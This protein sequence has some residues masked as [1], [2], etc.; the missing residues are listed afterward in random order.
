MRRFLYITF[1]GFTLIELLIVFAVLG[2]MGTLVMG[3]LARSRDEQSL[4]SSLEMTLALLGEARFKTLASEG[5]TRYGIYLGGTSIT[6]FRGSVYVSG[7]SDNTVHSFSGTT[8]IAT[9]SLASGTSTIL[10]NRLSGGTDN[11]GIVTLGNTTSSSTRQIKIEKT[12][13]SSSE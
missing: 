7:A 1:P 13:F 8:Y 5:D 4:S 2:I 9:T 10:F 12:G 6:L 3:P 11:Y